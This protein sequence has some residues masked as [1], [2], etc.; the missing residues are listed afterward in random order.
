MSETYLV[1]VD[2]SETAARATDYATAQAAKTG[3]ALLLVHVVEWSGFDVMGPE[4]LA[5][6]HAIRE[7]ELEAAQTNIVG[8]A[9]ERIQQAGVSV[10]SLI[11]HGHATETL[12][13]IAK[14]R[15]IDHIFVGRNGA[16]RLEALIFGST[17]NSLAQAS[18]VPVTVVP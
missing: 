8:P 14:E 17:T 6:R 16:S 9:V 15:Q 7:A 4:E 1:G 13:S 5:Q 3:A 2:S 18:P 12:L 10:E 11:H